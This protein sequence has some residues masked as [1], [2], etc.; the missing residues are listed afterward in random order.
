MWRRT[1]I[2]NTALLLSLVARAEDWPQ[3]L[4]PRRNGESVSAINL[5]W[6]REGPVALWQMKVGEGFSAPVV[7]DDKLV[8]FQRAANKER[9]DC[10]DSR[11]GRAIWQ[12][13]Y[14]SDYEDDFGRGN[15]PRA[16]PAIA[17]GR[18]FAFGAGGMFT[19]LNFTNGAKLWSVDTTKEFGAGKGFF[20]VACSPLVEGK[21]VLMNIGG[22]K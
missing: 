2:L 12:Y 13:E 6:P 7:A 10:V 22:R 20:G 5:Q 16:T 9:L 15:G 8:I 14:A 17:D 11:T 19:C 18:V 4:G 3:F 1:A 21:A